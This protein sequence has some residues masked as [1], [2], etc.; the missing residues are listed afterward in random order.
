MGACPTMSADSNK[1][2]ILVI[3]DEV[4]IRRL[5]RMTLEEEGID[6]LPS[7]GGGLM[8]AISAQ[9]SVAEGIV[10]FG[11]SSSGHTGQSEK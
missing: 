1:P 9:R 4:Q 10:S 11:G 5:L 8:N 3:D 6:T 7:R 2:E